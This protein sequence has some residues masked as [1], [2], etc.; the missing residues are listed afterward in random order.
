M[1]SIVTSIL[2]GSIKKVIVLTGA[3]VSV[4]SGIPD[5]RSK[6]GMYDTLKPHLLTA[7][8]SQRE[9]VIY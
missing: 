1:N 8:P 2:T 6:G 7:T 4:A 3:G 9:E 5:F